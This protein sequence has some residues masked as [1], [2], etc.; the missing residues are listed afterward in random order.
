M[1]KHDVG[2]RDDTFYPGS[3]TDNDHGERCL[4]PT[5]D[6]PD[7]HSDRK[8]TQRIPS[9]FQTM[10]RTG[11]VCEKK[12]CWKFVSLDNKNDMDW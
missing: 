11:E 9:L 12:A 6:I 1:T 8:R 3:E 7:F 10:Q 4:D 5:I 2:L